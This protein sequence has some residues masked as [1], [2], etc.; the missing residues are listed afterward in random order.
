MIR[1]VFYLGAPPPF[2]LKTSFLDPA[3]CFSRIFLR[4]FSGLGIGRSALTLGHLLSSPLP[5]LFP[6]RPETSPFRFLPPPPNDPF[7]SLRYH[8]N[9]RPVLQVQPLPLSSPS[10]PFDVFFPDPGSISTVLPAALKLDHLLRSTALG[11]S[12][13]PSFTICWLVS[14]SFLFCPAALSL[15]SLES[16][17]IAKTLGWSVG[18]LSFAEP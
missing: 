3:V 1:P 18:A 8:Q 12:S 5:F 15:P 9:P 10:S 13:F 14:L 16:Q 11:R 17:E 4:G 6:G 2:P 7:W